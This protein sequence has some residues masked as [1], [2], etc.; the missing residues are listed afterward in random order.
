MSYDAR[1]LAPFGYALADDP[2]EFAERHN[3]LLDAETQTRLRIADRDARLND[4]CRRVAR[5]SIAASL[6]VEVKLPS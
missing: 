2:K 6:A 1:A 5:Q 4:I 3:A